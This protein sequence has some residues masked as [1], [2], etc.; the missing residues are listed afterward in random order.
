[1]KMQDVDVE[2]YTVAIIGGQS[3]GKSTLLNK[4]F[5]TQFEVLMEDTFGMR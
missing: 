3:S 2:Y 1:M 5:D 4:V